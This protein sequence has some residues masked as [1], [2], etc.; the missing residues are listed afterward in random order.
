LGDVAR[1]ARHKK[2]QNTLL[3]V[4]D[5][6]SSP[7]PKVITNEEI[8]EVSEDELAKESSERD[9]TPSN[10]PHATTGKVPP[11]VWKSKILAQK[12]AI[13]SQETQIQRVNDSI[14]FAS[15]NCVRGCVQWNER[16]LEKQ[17]EV[18]R[19]RANLEEQKKHLQEM[20]EGARQQGYGGSVY[21]P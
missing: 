10:I 15:G 5:E 8:P 13:A 2:Q 18:E 12:N 9:S 19:M 6:R 3:Q 1:Q 11:E 17:D 21:D 16:Q 4:K 14:H 20:E 7:P